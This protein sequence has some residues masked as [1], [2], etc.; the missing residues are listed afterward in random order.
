MILSALLLHGCEHE[1][2]PE[3]P[4]EDPPETRYVARGPHAVGFAVLDEVKAWYPA[5]A[6]GDGEIEYSIQL[7]LLGFPP[8]PVTILGEA[9]RDAAVNT[10]DGPYPLVVLSHGFS[11]NPEWYHTLAE[12][13]ASH[14]LVVLGPEH[15]ES[16]WFVDVV[17]A[18]VSRPADIRATIDLAESGVL[19]GAVDTEHVAVVGHSYGGYTALAMGGAQFDLQSLPAR[20]EGVEDPFV[21]AYFCEPFLSAGPTLAELMGLETEPSG[22]WPGL[23]DDRVDAIVPIAGDAYLFGELGHA[24]IQIPTMLLGGTADTAT[25]W[26]WG[27]GLSF[28]AISSEDLSLVTLEG[29]EHFFPVTLCE[30]MPWTEGLPPEYYGY[31]C[32]DPAWDKQEALD[33]VHHF[34]TAF[35]LHVL[36]GDPAASEVLDP[37]HYPEGLLIE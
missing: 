13:L 7:K 37:A 10:Q 14:G 26:D 29:A 18:T 2:P 16:D 1:A 5:D 6:E 30:N 25:P 4:H 31:I 33:I 9:H 22:L 36:L 15:V 35:L 27:A 21:A 8:E 3:A 23:G 32:E 11:M 34:T 17:A 24:S 28:D 12:H 20:C 19:E